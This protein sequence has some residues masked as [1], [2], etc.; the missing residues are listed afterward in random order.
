MCMRRKHNGIFTAGLTEQCP[1]HVYNIWL[2]FFGFI[3]L[4]YTLLQPVTFCLNQEYVTA[5]APIKTTYF[6][7]ARAPSGHHT[8]TIQSTRNLQYCCDVCSNKA[9]ENA[10]LVH[11]LLNCKDIVQTTWVSR[12]RDRL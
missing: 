1:N 6:N 11:L 8:H 10:S 3:N 9:K 2:S 4:S 7:D 5:F 12:Q